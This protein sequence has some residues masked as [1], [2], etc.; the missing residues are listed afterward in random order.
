M[1]LPQNPLPSLPWVSRPRPVARPRA[2]LICFPH[3]GG[4][5]IGFWPWSAAFPPDIEVATALL[6]GR[7]KRRNEPPFTRMPPLVAALEEGLAPLLDVP[8]ALFGHSMGAIVAFEL[9]RA[10]RRRGSPLPV[11][12][13]VAAYGAPSLGRPFARMHDLPEPELLA[14]LARIGGTPK[15]VLD[16]PYARDA[17]VPL[18]RADFA[19][20][21]TWIYA[22]EAPLP[23][24][25]TAFGGSDDLA[26]P[27][28]RLEAWRAESARGF[29]LRTFPG[30][31]F[32]VHPAP[33]AML[34]E[35]AATLTAAIP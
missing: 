23:V 17:I 32:F 9:I 35:I 15:S 12:L 8:F 7:S 14:E 11:H 25:I 19:V 16:E 4:S 33:A 34:E 27:R 31:H 5:P 21:E 22:P 10:L 1:T 29:G 24:P 2:R 18:L 3:A 6:P 30:D 28:A 20:M 26:A 13:F